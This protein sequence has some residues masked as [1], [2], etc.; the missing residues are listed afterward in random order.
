[1][2]CFGFPTCGRSFH[3]CSATISTAFKTNSTASCDMKYGKLR[4]TKPGLENTAFLKLLF[5][6]NLVLDFKIEGYRFRPSLRGSC[7]KGGGVKRGK[8]C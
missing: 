6:S 5:K 8:T 1:M 3:P 2:F 7:P 4:R